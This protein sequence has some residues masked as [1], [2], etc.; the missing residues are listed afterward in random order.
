[1]SISEQWEHMHSRREW[2][3]YPNEHLVA[4]SMRTFPSLQER[5]ETAVLDLGFG[6]GGNLKFFCE[7][8][9]DVYGVEGSGSALRKTRE[10]LCGLGYAPELHETD[11]CDLSV[12]PS[13]KF[14]LVTDIRSM[15]NMPINQMSLVISE[16]YRVLACG[17]YFLTKL[18]GKGCM[19]YEKGRQLGPSTFSDVP[20]G[21]LASI[22]AV[23]ILASQEVRSLLQSLTIVT[24]H[25]ISET[26]FNGEWAFEDHWVVCQKL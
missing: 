26:A 10:F 7:Q 18:Y 5:L 6:G 22:G 12:F 16:V 8:G 13:E 11:M 19:S 2:G 24:H 3:K 1:M 25:V 15:S 21:P 14:N 23:T 9:F 17:G 4:F 20:D